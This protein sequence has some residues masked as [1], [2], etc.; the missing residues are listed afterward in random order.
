[1]TKQEKEIYQKHLDGID[2]VEL[3]HLYNKPGHEINGI[4][5]KGQQENA[6]ACGGAG[7]RGVKPGEPRRPMTWIEAGM[8]VSTIVYAALF[9]YALFVIF[10]GGG[11][12]Q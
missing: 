11:P 5:L 3:T 7:G 10:T 1:M 9:L 8:L 4:I 2:W 6:A 12:T